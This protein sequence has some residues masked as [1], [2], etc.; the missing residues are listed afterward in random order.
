VVVLSMKIITHNDCTTYEAPGHPER[1][2]RIVRTVERLKAQKELALE[3]VQPPAEVDEAA[4]LRA[5]APALLERLPQAYDFDMDTPAYPG[6]DT[7][8]RRSVAGALH[9]LACARRGERVFSLLRPPGHHATRSKA[10]GFCYLNSAAIATLAARADGVDKVAV[11]DFDVHHGNGTEDILV[12]QPGCAFFSIHQFPAYPGTGR[13][14]R[15]SNCFNFVVPPST[16]RE[17]YH[18]VAERALEGLI[19]FKPDLVC[20]SAGF[21]AYVRDPLCQQRLEVEDFHWYG[22]AFR[23]LGVPLFSLLEGG[24]SDDL[25]ELIHAYLRG[26]AGLAWGVGRLPS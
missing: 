10:M 24:Y 13:R 25:P 4:L 21:D 19:K 11:F 1:P 2:A 5:H 7:H 6:I 14:N 16:S 18:E 22:R 20:V 3:W 12:D 9:A 17:G 26:L 23:L 8:A 15:G